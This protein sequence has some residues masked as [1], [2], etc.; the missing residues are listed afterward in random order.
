L[1]DTGAPQELETAIIVAVSTPGRHE[2]TADDRLD[3]L[4]SL[5]DTAG[6]RVAERVV[7]NRESPDPAYLI[8]RG[9]V[10]EIEDLRKTLGADLVVF[11]AQLSPGQRRNLER[12]IGCKVID[13][14]Q[15]ILDIFAQRAR[16]RE[17]K[18]Q[19]ELAQLT[20]SLTQLVG[21]RALS[22]LGGGIGTRGPGE[23]KLEVDRRRIRQR[24]SGLRREIEAVRRHRALGRREREKAPVAVAALAGYTNAG[25]STLL[26]NLT[27]SSV[28][29]EDKL[30]ATLDPTTRRMR[31]P[32]GQELLVTDTVGF[33]RDL[34]HDLVAAF[35]ATLEEI[36]EA[37]LIIHVVDASHPAAGKQI[38]IVEGA[39]AAIGAADVPVI[40]ALNK[41]D[42]GVRAT[43]AS[44]RTAVMISALTG[45]GFGELLTAIDA[46]LGAK[47]QVVTLVLPYSRQDL[48]ALLHEHGKVTSEQYGQHAIT[49]TGEVESVWAKRLLRWASQLKPGSNDGGGSNGGPKGY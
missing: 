35:S 42:L 45:R 3:E 15:V 13:R 1:D 31:L 9:K 20:Y 41:M 7:Q 36:T 21:S 34:P 11:D 27:G 6:A 30:F 5:L 37:D 19:V 25:K 2:W 40:L 33:I 32:S 44:E 39:L 28:F 10:D 46:E 14:T 43:V 49:V 26:N 12:H 17:G 8:G 18:L 38:E 16:T 24:V 22:R 4:E 48:I 47:R 29:V 23:T